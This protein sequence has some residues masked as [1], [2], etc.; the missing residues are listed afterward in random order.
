MTD[1]TLD[2]LNILENKIL[3]FGMLFSQLLEKINE[4]MNGGLFNNLFEKEFEGGI[5]ALMNNLYSL[6]EEFH[7]RVDE[8]Y[9]EN[10]YSH[11]NKIQNDFNEQMNSLNELKNKLK[12]FNFYSSTNN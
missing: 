1:I 3:E 11:L 6:K 2:N 8:I 4:Y 9:K 5:D 10:N 7:K 12:I